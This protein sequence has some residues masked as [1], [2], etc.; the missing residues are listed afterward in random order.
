L[1]VALAA[2]PPF[3]HQ[4]THF[5]LKR[6]LNTAKPNFPHRPQTSPGDPGVPNW[7]STFRIIT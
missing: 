2:E 6:S 1:L 4:S 7:E 3:W 5:T